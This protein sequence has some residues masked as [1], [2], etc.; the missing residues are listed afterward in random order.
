MK[1]IWVR[2]YIYK[3]FFVG[4][5]R[6]KSRYFKMNRSTS[7]LASEANSLVNLFILKCI[8]N[9]L[10]DWGSISGLVI[11]K[12]SK[13]WYL[14]FPCLTLSIIRYVSRVKWSNP[15][16]GV[17]PSLTPQYSSYWKGS[18]WLRSPTLLICVCVCVYIYIYIYIYS[19]IKWRLKLG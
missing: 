8:T 9:G 5:I 2:S 14:I 4:P 12:D 7:K 17:A 16:K 15:G 3:I 1:T 10:G 6:E 11:P 19:T 18:H 13:K